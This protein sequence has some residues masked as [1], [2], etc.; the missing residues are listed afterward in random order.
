MATTPFCMTSLRSSLAVK[1]T[2]TTINKTHFY[3]WV[4]TN[5][6]RWNYFF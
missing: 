6:L 2:L 4:S 1:G 3:D 5:L